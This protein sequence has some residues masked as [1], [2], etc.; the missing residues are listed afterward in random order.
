MTKK[1]LEFLSRT[2]GFI[3]TVLVKF[4]LRYFVTGLYELLLGFAPNSGHDSMTCC[5][6]LHQIRG[7]IA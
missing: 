3:K 1:I 5:L 7:M 4:N 2:D 6:A